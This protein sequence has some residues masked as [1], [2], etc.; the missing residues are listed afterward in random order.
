MEPSE[1]NLL[2]KF[3]EDL[4]L[5]QPDVNRHK[6]EH[7]YLRRAPPLI[8][9]T[10]TRKQAKQAMVYRHASNQKSKQC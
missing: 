9:V 6:F 10:Q 8:A 1:I 5:S 4:D 7:I 2:K 3:I